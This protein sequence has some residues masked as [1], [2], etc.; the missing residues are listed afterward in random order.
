[1][2]SN[3]LGSMYLMGV[4]PEDGGKFKGIA[5]YNPCTWCYAGTSKGRVN[6]C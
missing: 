2:P 1:M 3:L 6:I 5:S 4:L